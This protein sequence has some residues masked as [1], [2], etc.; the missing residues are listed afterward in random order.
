MKQMQVFT[1]IAVIT[2]T[3][4]VATVACCLSRD[5]T[6]GAAQQNPVESSADLV[7]YQDVADE[8]GNS[9]GSTP[10]ETCPGF[11]PGSRSRRTRHMPDPNQPKLKMSIPH[12]RCKRKHGD[13]RK[14]QRPRKRRKVYVD[15]EALDTV[16][17]DG[18]VTYLL[19][20]TAQY[21]IMYSHTPVRWI[22]TQSPFFSK[23]KMSKAL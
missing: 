7:G 22:A 15:Q 3:L 21:N 17:I 5:E 10:P 4:S 23:T 12:K 20:G 9:Q 2:T 18:T 11:P 14:S 13:V 6:T 1:V 19:H 16:W 8:T